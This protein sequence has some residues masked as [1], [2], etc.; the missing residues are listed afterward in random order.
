MGS[1]GKCKAMRV[2]RGR[3]R[4]VEGMSRDGEKKVEVL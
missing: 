1:G 4:G 3:C 2:A